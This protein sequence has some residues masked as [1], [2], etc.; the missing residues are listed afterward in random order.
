MAEVQSLCRGMLSFDKPA[1]CEFG[2]NMLESLLYMWRELDRGGGC[3]GVHI[4]LVGF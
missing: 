1:E 2:F 4:E 3:H